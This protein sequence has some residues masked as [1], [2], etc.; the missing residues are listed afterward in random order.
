MK[1][2]ISLIF[3]IVLISGCTKVNPSVDALAN[4]LAEKGVKEYG[5]FWCPNCAKQEKL[6]GSSFEIIKEKVYLECDPRCDVEDIKDLPIACRG[7]L[8]Q[9]ELCLQKNINKYPTWE[10]SNGETLI[11]VQEFSTLAEMAG[12]KFNEI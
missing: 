4:C 5:A 10:F 3:L 12:C 7:K 1:K 8:G 2:L 11:G 9:T 6:F